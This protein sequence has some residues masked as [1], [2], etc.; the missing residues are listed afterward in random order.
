MDSGRY[1]PEWAIYCHL[2]FGTERA[3]I[4]PNQQDATTVICQVYGQSES[5][6]Y[7]KRDKD[8][9]HAYTEEKSAMWP[10]GTAEVETQLWYSNCGKCNKNFFVW[11]CRHTAI[12][13][14]QLQNGTESYIVCV[15]LDSKQCLSRISRGWPS[16]GFAF[17][18]SHKLPGIN[19]RFALGYL[20]WT[21]SPETRGSGG[22][23]R[24]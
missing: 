22:W 21:W 12:A 5:Y 20:S 4:R 10:W 15:L 3:T 13:S 14:I 16:N 1:L 24:L 8:L 11:F 6:I 18:H 23:C 9:D 2:N 17:A 7:T 19:T